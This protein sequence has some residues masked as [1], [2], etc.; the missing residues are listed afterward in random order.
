MQH[1]LSN[2]WTIVCMEAGGVKKAPRIESALDGH[3]YDK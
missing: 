1:A 3:V 2:F